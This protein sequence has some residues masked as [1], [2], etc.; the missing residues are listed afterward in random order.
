MSTCR[1][2]T[3]KALK[4]VSLSLALVLGG[5]GDPVPKT[6]GVY[7]QDGRD[8]IPISENNSVPASISKTSRVVVY[9]RSLFGLDGSQIGSLI[10]RRYDIR[11]GVE[12]LSAPGGGEPTLMV[13]KPKKHFV[14]DEESIPVS[15]APIKSHDDMVELLFKPVLENGNYAIVV[16]DDLYSFNVGKSDSECVDEYLTT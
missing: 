7:V 11:A 12:W 3:A 1:Q 13:Y 15:V 5:C 4:A 16:S 9:D 14:W 6:Y 10:H 8:L 2:F